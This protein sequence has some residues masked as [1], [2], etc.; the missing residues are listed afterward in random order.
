MESE[1]EVAEIL[2]RAK[3]EEHKQ[4]QAR[5]RDDSIKQQ[6]QNQADQVANMSPEQLR[7]QAQMMR[8]MDAA[9]IRRMNPG[10]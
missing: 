10:D 4:S 6:I 3:I 8:S 7:A 2:A 5:K 1:T 9:S